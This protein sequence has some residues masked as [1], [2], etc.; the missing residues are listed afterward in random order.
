MATDIFIFFLCCCMYC[1]AALAVLEVIQ[2]E[3]L[4]NNAAGLGKYLI[5]ELIS[6]CSST[7]FDFIITYIVAGL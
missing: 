5:Q 4:V 2:Q 3:Y 6:T 7:T 1:A